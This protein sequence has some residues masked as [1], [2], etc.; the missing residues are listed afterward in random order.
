MVAACLLMTVME[1]LL[2]GERI[3]ALRGEVLGLAFVDF[4]AVGML[5]SMI[6]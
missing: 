4:G 1:V 3:S 5:S 6:R 2:S